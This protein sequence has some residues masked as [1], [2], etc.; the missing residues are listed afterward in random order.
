MLLHPLSGSSRVELLAWRGLLLD[1][2][3]R[4]HSA[5]YIQPA[6]HTE[7]PLHV[8]TD[9]LPREPQKRVK[10]HTLVYCQSGRERF[11]TNPRAVNTLQLHCYSFVT[12]D[13]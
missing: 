1:T 5:K 3:L 10:L 11:C 2:A 13:G 8:Q 4:G 12:G 7:I 6:V 9:T